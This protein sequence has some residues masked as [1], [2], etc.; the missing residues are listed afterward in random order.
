MIT[1]EIFKRLEPIS[2]TDRLLP[3]G[4]GDEFEAP[5]LKD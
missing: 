5:L 3:V 1:A 2:K 4:G